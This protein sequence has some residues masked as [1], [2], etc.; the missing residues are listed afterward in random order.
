MTRY[1]ASVELDSERRTG[2]VYN[3]ETGK[4]EDEGGN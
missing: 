2:T 4:Y 3:H 1:K